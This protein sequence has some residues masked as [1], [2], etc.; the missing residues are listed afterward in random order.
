MSYY[1]K[2]LPETIINYTSIKEISKAIPKQ[3]NLFSVW[4]EDVAIE[5]GQMNEIGGRYG[6][7]SLQA[8]VKALA[9]S[10]HERSNNKF[11]FYFT[12]SIMLIF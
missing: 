7:L 2:L 12:Q 10:P 11:L 1:R 3:L 8:A 4:E 5:P 6:V 9:W